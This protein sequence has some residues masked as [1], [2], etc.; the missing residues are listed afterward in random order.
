METKSFLKR[1]LARGDSYC[2]FAAKPDGVKKQ[3]FYTSIDAVIGASEQFDADDYDVYFGLATF[4]GTGTRKAQNTLHM[5][6]LFVDLD[7]GPTKDYADQSEA[8]KDLQKFCKV[9]DMPKPIMV[10]SGYGIHAYWP[11]TDDVDV[12]DWKPVAEALKRTAAARGLY[13]DPNVT[14]DAARILRMPGTRNHKRDTP[15][16]VEVLA[17]GT[18]DAHPLSF[19]A[20]LLRAD[21]PLPKVPGKL[22]DNVKMTFDDDPVMQRLMRNRESSFKR[23]LQK[24]MSGHGCAQLHYTVTNQAEVDEPMWRATLSIAKFCKDSERAA[25][26]VSK[27]HP[28][29]DPD[30]TEAKLDGI[31]GPYTCKTFASCNPGGCDGCPLRGKITSP[32]QIGTIVEE[33]E[34]EEVENDA[35]EPVVVY[36]GTSGDIPRYPTPYMRGPSG[37]VFVRQKD[38]EGEIEEVMVY[39]NDLYYTKRVVDPEAG[40]CI[41]GRLHLPNDDAREFAVP[42]VSATSKEELRKILSKYGVAVGG[43]RWEHVMAYTQA[44]IEQ[45]QV[46]TIA[47]NARTQF[48]WTD[49]KF[50]SYVVGDREIFADRVG[51]N[52]P[53]SK[54]SFLFPAFKPRGTL[55][56]WVEQ[57]KFYNRPGLEPYQFVVCQAL[58]APLM[59]FM[60]V[61]AAIFDFYS[62]GSGHGKSTTQKFALTAYGD[63]SDLMVGPKDTLNARMN[64]MEL[65]KDV[66]LQFDEFTEFPAE[67]TSDLIYGATDGRQKARMA[68]GSNEERYRG[69]AWHTTLTASSN[70]SMLA[71]VY[72]RKAT[73]EAEVQRVL[74]YHVQPHN[75]T[76]K[77][78]TD[79]FAKGVGNN[80]G[81]AIEVFVQRIM[82]DVETTR[83]LLNTIQAKL[84]KACDLTMKNRFWSVQGAVVMTALVLARDAGLLSYDPAALYKWIVELIKANKADAKGSVVS[85]DTL[86]NDFVHE[87]YGSI[88]WIKSTE[89]LR[90]GKNSNGLDSLVVPEM[91]PRATLVARYET[92]IKKLYIAL[93]P[94]KVWCTKQRLNYDSVVKQMAEKYGAQKI[95]IRMSKGTKLNLPT[96]SV[97]AIDCSSL[98]LPEGPD[99]GAE[100]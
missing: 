33:A 36:K 32:I 37:G 97:I 98:D 47:D 96:A 83:E 53:S 44:W 94:L 29:Y 84:D 54:T 14:A 65:M 87:N 76:D 7:C 27:E 95:K 73:P 34:T 61:H 93:K 80:C 11:L 89:D 67:D 9:V 70:H 38:D 18:V 39:M 30:V 51:Y 57:A 8:L 20:D 16:P 43:K 78:E 60:P 26:F 92:D 62:D 81:H 66:A 75:F 100:T 42:L 25:H 72:A 24:T 21:A 5:R 86:I 48:G 13:I 35:G 58:A 31:K 52:P 69:D 74:R 50:T 77:R 79:I 15:A 46:T 40:E 19:F 82:Q 3:K 4:D 88:L 45:L 91:Q 10:S 90:G 99:G 2:V 64:R 17:V 63:P 23:I 71:K 1:V 59:R 85:I 49:D 28:D 68:A 12:C 22:F 56:G 55:E 41:I 6:S